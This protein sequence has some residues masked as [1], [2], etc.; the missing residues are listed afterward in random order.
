MA[1]RCFS[2]SRCF[3]VFSICQWRHSVLGILYQ[4]S[5]NKDW[6]NFLFIAGKKKLIL[7]LRSL[8]SKWFQLKTITKFS[9]DPTMEDQI[10]WT[11][12]WI[13]K[14]KK[15]PSLI[16]LWGLWCS[17]LGRW[18][19]TVPGEHCQKIAVSNPTQ[20]GQRFTWLKTWFG[21]Q[22][23]WKAVI[24]GDTVTRVTIPIRGHGKITWRRPEVKFGWNVVK[25]ENNTKTT[26]IRTKK[27]KIILRLRSLI[28]KWFQLKTITKIDLFI[29]ITISAG[30][31]QLS[32]QSTWYRFYL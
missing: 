16:A 24:T 6:L 20:A 12:N 22:Q 23:L 9:M 30:F 4:V 17:G 14:T 2:I 1:N 31:F 27:I 21:W 15:N 13:Y 10:R 5:V 18:V 11:N 25:A 8:I 28:S 7:R 19:F 29:F 32:I 3:L 26:K